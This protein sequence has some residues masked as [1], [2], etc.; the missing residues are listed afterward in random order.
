MKIKITLGAALIA[1][2]IAMGPQTVAQPSTPEWAA[3]AT[4]YEMNVRQFTP[5]GT[6]A[7]AQGHLQRLAD[8]GIEIVWVMPIHP[9][10]ELNRK[11]TLGSYYAVRDYREINPEFGTKADFQNFVNA[12]HEL[13][14]KVII[15]WVANHTS[16]DNVWIEQGHLDWYT[17]D[18]NGQVQPTL[19]TDWWDV[20]DLNYD[21]RE[22]REAM[23]QAMEYWVREFDI[24]GYRCDVAEW[25]P[26]D[27]WEDV[28]E[29]LDSIKPVFMLAEA[30]NE[31]L[32][33][34]AFDMTYGWSFHAFMNQMAKG[35]KNVTDLITH[36]RKNER[37]RF[38]AHA[39]RMHFT[40]NHDENSWNGTTTERLGDAR[41]TYAVLAAT[42]HSM[43]LVYN[44]QESDNQ[45]RLEFFEKDTI[46]WGDYPLQ[47]FYSKLLHLNQENCALANDSA[48]RYPYFFGRDTI[49]DRAVAYLRVGMAD[50][51]MLKDD[52]VVVFLNFS[53]RPVTVQYDSKADLSGKYKE[54]F[55][56]DKYTFTSFSGELELAPY[57]YRVYL[58]K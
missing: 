49:T 19:G 18:S 5:E 24:D 20:A 55:T 36:F 30:E 6:F 31:E 22:M 53:D 44:G 46:H 9:I 10:G 2:L 58:K 3:N 25:V 12:A 13:G 48:A 47:D 15:D 54:L 29:R 52:M 56:G 27:F 38:P 17:L 41:L 45:E 37:R 7:K 34:H 50:G 1:A 26:L 14:L 39:Y 21:S 57:E 4:I 16:P 8:M 23:T 51:A 11:G 32:H 40:S 33:N 42:I 35:E 28:R 43:P